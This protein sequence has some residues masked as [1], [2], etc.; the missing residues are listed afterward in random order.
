[1]KNVLITGATGGIGA[2]IAAAFAKSGYSVIAH[3]NSKPEKARQLCENLTESFGVEAYPVQADVSN[4]RSVSE[5]FGQIS[6]RSGKLDS[7]INN[8]GIAQQKLFTDLTDEDWSKMRGINLDGVFFCC[9]EALKRFML[10]AHSGAIVNISSMWG[11]VGA[12]CEVHYSAAKAG[13]IGLSKALAKEVGLSGIRVN[14]V[15]PGVVMTDM[16][17]SF[18][19]AAIQ[20]LRE[21]TPLN[22]LGTPEDIAQAAV[23]LCSD[24]ARFITGQVLGVNGGFVI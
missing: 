17:K 10:P 16:M 9:R 2:A 19:E 1:M 11:Q 5:M 4:S 12:S 22:I 8:A 18:D 23:F 3:T 7:L 15:C 21:E 14:C 13:V 6:K 24:K 20:A